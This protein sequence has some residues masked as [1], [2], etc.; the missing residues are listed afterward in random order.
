ME[1]IA[2]QGANP[3]TI[4]T[5]GDIV[6]YSVPEM[7]ITGDMLETVAK[8]CNISQD[9]LPGK[10][11]ASDAFK[12]A[13]TT[14]SRVW[15]NQS[16]D[17]GNDQYE[18]L[19]IRGIVANDF[20]IVKNVVAEI[21]N[22]A[23]ELTSYRTVAK[24]T[25]DYKAGSVSIQ[26]LEPQYEAQIN[27]LQ[28]EF[29]HAMVYYNAQTI[30]VIIKGLIDAM[31]PVKARPSGA[32]YF[33]PKEFSDMLD[34]TEALVK[35]T[36]DYRTSNTESTFARI[37]LVDSVK[38]RDMVQKN[39]ELQVTEQVDNAIAD[40]A[41]LLKQPVIKKSQLT[42]FMT[43]GR[44]LNETVQKYEGVLEKELSVARMKKDVFNNQVIEAVKKVNIT[45]EKKD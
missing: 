26:V 35:A 22:A 31:A 33:I 9:Y 29:N 24:I 10:I 39:L 19:L 3:N 28:D 41:G 43:M 32:V 13:T 7:E 21:R 15:Q 42:K 34:A 18:K 14:M 8:K 4:P 20:K 27:P 2:V 1:V 5:I 17:L 23:Q 16:A 36:N 11:I 30:R 40:L 6:W 37:P 38:Q 45:E 25:F 44:E 12:R